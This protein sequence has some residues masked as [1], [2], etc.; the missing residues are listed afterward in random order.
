[1]SERH[2]P[3]V[4][5]KPAYLCPK[6]GEG[7][8]EMPRTCLQCG[9]PHVNA[10]EMLEDAER[11]RMAIAEPDAGWVQATRPVSPG[12]RQPTRV[13]T[14]ETIERWALETFG[15]TGSDFAVASRANLEM[16]ELLWEVS[17]GSGGEKI[18]EECADVVI[19]LTRLAAR[20]GID[21]WQAIDAKMAKN[22]ARRWNLTA[23]GFGQHVA[24]APEGER[25][26]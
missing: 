2:I 7:Y 22:R 20:N 16:A 3:D 6:C 13:E 14:P 12:I 24:D 25:D 23:D 8:A 17:I 9:L 15:P 11:W 5:V 10:K 19:V 18:A 26:G 4:R 21:L 1:M